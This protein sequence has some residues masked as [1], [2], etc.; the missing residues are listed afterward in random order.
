MA[1]QSTHCSVT[2]WAHLRICH[3]FISFFSFQVYTLRVVPFSVLFLK[4]LVWSRYPIVHDLH[5][6][7]GFFSTCCLVNQLLGLTMAICSFS[8]V[9]NFLSGFWSTYQFWSVCKKNLVRF[10]NVIFRTMDS[11]DMM[12]NENSSILKEYVKKETIDQ[13]ATQ[14]DTQD[15][16]ETFF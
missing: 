10:S 13:D 16:A 14:E 3:F 4:L 6:V 11:V 2:G 5:I 12:Q 1:V 9:A 7:L 8:A 15:H